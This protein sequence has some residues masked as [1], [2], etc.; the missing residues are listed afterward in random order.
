M[1]IIIK[2]KNYTIMKSDNIKKDNKIKIFIPKDIE[3]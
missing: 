2:K 1:K 3:A